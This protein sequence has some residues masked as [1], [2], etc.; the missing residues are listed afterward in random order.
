MKREQRIVIG[1]QILRENG[2]SAIARPTSGRRW[3]H[4]APGMNGEVHDS[5]GELSHDDHHPVGLEEQRLAAEQVDDHKCPWRAEEGEPGRA[6]RRIRSIVLSERAPDDILVDI[7]PEYEGE[8]IGDPLVAESRIPSF[9]LTIAAT[10]SRVGP[11]GPG[12]PR[13][14]GVNSNRYLR[15]TP[16]ETHDL[17]GLSTIALRS[18]RVAAHQRCAE[19]SDDSIDRLK[20]GRSFSRALEDQELVLDQHGLRDDSAQTA[21][22]AQANQR[23]DQ[24]KEQNRQVRQFHVR[25]RGALRSR[26][27]GVLH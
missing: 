12:L 10:S 24:M 14:F 8:L 7:E 18:S 19:S 26:T 22:S 17:E 5:T 3:V 20:I 15:V 25:A 27:L 1:A 11:F 13:R 16:V 9:H 2:A 23:D 21:R 4:R 6:V